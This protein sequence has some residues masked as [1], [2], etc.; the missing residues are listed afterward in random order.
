MRSGTVWHGGYSTR[1]SSAWPKDASVCTLSDALETSNVP[2]KYYLSPRACDG[3]IRR[4]EKRGKSL[5]PEL[6]AALRA[7]ASLG[8]TQET[9]D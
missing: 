8:T 9:L 6:E 4:A 5:P 3:I 2:A 7:Q 1:N